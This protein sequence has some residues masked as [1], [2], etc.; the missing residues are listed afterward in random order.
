MQRRD[1]ALPAPRADALRA[2]VSP[3]TGVGVP[4]PANNQRGNTPGPE[5]PRGAARL[6]GR[7]LAGARERRENSLNFELCNTVNEA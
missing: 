2:V 1:H 7:R 3:R 5:R 6:P 4:R